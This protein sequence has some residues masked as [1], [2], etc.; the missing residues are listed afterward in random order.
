MTGTK[1]LS[2]ASMG[3]A[4][5]CRR[6]ISAAAEEE[7]SAGGGGGSVDGAD[8]ALRHAA[9]AASASY[10]TLRSVG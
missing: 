3:S 1:P 7:D 6:D 5:A 9:S 4:H 2:D 8:A 10:V